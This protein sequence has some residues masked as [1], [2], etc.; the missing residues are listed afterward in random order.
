MT[1]RH[2]SFFL[3]FLAG[4]ATLGAGFMLGQTR[5]AQA[6]TAPNPVG[7]QATIQ[8]RQIEIVDDLG[9]VVTVLGANADGGSISLR[10]SFG[11]TLILASATNDGGALA[12]K[13]TRNDSPVFLAKATADGGA[14][15][16]FSADGSPRISIRSTKLGGSISIVN[17]ED[18]TIVDL[19]TDEQ[20]AGRITA[21]LKAGREYARIYPDRAGAGVIETYTTGGSRLVSLGSTVGGH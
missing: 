17:E 8:A 13:N 10:D 11:R 21:A 18:K 9:R 15:Q 2:T 1:P 12:V 7:G 19:A 16:W 5:A 14:S 20:G 4:L 6:Q 3:G